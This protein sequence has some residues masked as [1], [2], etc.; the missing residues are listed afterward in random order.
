MALVS[1]AGPLLEPVQLSD[2]KAHLRVSEN[3]EDVLI[4]SLITAARVHIEHLLT[5][6]LMTQS[7]SYLID[8]W[9]DDDTVILPINPVQSISAIQIYDGDDNVTVLSPTDYYADVAADPGRVIWLGKAV[10][11]NPERV[12]TQV[13]FVRQGFR[14]QSSTSHTPE[15]RL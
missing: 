6:A 14:P 9:P 8:A 5:R 7:W 12:A 1:I 15:C 11:P 4:T 2:I 3:D 10:R 13:R